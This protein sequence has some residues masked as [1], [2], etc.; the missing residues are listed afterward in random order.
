MK[1]NQF[2]IILFLIVMF[3]GAVLSFAYSIGNP[4]LAVCIFFAGAAA[5]YLCKS[6]VEGVVED[7]R[8]R[9]VSQKASYITFQVVVFSFAVGGA[10]LIAMKNTYPGYTNLGFFM[11]YASCAAIALYGLLYMYYN[12]EYGG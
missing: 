10:A 9:Q 3:M 6:R 12:R 1:R 11:A 2:T 8:V 5:I 7:E 4:V